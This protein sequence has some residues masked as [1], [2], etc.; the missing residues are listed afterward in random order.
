[1][2]KFFLFSA[3]LFAAWT[4][5]AG[6]VNIDLSKATITSSAVS[7][8]LENDELTVNYDIK[9]SWGN[10]GVTFT[11]DDLDVTELAFEYKGDE[12]VPAWVSFIVYLM[13]SQGGMWYSFDADLSI[14]EWNAEW[15]G[16]AFMPT[17][18]LWDSSLA[19]EPVKPFKQLGF[20][21][22]PENPTSASFAIRNIKLTVNG[23]EDITNTS[24][25]SKAVKVIRDGQVLILRD[26]KTFNALGAEMK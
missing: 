2:K 18:V 9:Q 6:V 10:E 26:G 8:N 21:A 20:L 5:N 1:M 11:L 25:Q 4:V 23:S 22:N 13:D 15:E 12:S 16:K 24:V 14:S 3:A 19:S 7:M 17:D